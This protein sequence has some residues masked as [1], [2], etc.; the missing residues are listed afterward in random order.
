MGL[1]GAEVFFNDDYGDGP[2][3]PGHRP[4]CPVPINP[5]PSYNITL[6]LETWEVENFEAE[7]FA[8]VMSL[9]AQRLSLLQSENA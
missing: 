2:L 4:R 7:D 1:W 6:S 8:Q 5:V 3:Y 9:Y